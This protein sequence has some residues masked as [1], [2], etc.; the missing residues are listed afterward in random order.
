[1]S[2]HPR[3]RADDELADDLRDDDGLAGAAEA[4][5]ADAAAGLDPDFEALLV[6]LRERRGFDFTGYKR[7]SLVR[8]VRRR[9]A[10]V[11]TGSVTEYQDFLEVHPDEFAPLFNTILINVTGFFRD[12]PS[13]EHLRER[14]LPDLLATA[15]PRIRLWSAGCASGQEAYSLAMLLAEAL[16]EGE[17]R[18]RVKI[19]ATDVDEEALTQARQALYT[20]R[21]MAGLTPEEAGR[22]FTQEGSRF[23]F[24]KDLRRAVIFGRND[25]VQDAP[26]SHVDL[27]LCRN[28]LMYFNA[29]TQNRILSRLHFALNR[30]GVLFLGKA[31]MLL[32]H[33]QLFAPVDLTRRFFRKRDGGVAVER[34]PGPALVQG[35]GGP[36][37]GDLARLRLEAVRSAPVAQL[38]LDAGGR[39]AMANHQ[40]QRLFRVDERDVGRPFQDLEV[41]YRPAELR[42]AVAEAVAGRRGVWLRGV[43]R[44]QPG[45]EP[46]VLDV[47]VVP[48]YREDGGPLGTTVTFEDVT[49]YRR[50]QRELESANRQL[51]TAYEELQSTNEELETTNEELQSTVEE[52]ET[53]NEELQS[54]N[55][56]LETMNEELQSM[57]DELHSTNEE[58]RASTDEVASLNQFMAGVLSSFRAGVVVVDAEL[59]VL[60]WNAAAEDL[61]GVREDEAV[62]QYLLNLDI[63]LP[64]SQLHPLLRR[65][66]GGDGPAHETVELGAVNRRGRPVR[67][68]VTVSEFATAPGRRGGAV[69]LMD[70][71]DA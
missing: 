43:E 70:P 2:E 38:V 10:E 67:V 44:H 57:N 28:T 71:A 15:G 26:I 45:G 40:A 4:A 19:Y 7:P 16:G 22:Y 55:E 3:P 54:T 1:M 34:R 5:D 49:R 6:Y 23:A 65:Q 41:S 8:R 60:A 17:F 11:G 52:L 69:L 12:R 68:R 42:G 21:E 32:S 33:A 47:Q 18:E 35:D 20:E 46:L 39:L 29:E 25:L 51:E 14:V 37:D 63:G 58:L 36:S 62:G 50:L 27:L 13:W 48:L 66:V 24:R 9:M 59:Q 53:T 31:E 61:W 56:E 64:V 30:N